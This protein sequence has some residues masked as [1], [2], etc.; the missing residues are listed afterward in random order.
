[1]QGIL[2]IITR[3]I[4]CGAKFVTHPAYFIVI[5]Q[6]CAVQNIVLKLPSKISVL[7]NELAHASKR[8]NSNFCDNVH[9]YTV[10]TIINLN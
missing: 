8:I 1:M 4:Q 3:V 5:K 2:I 10:L 9:F 6:R 7:L